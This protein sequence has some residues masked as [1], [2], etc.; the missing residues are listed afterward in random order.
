MLQFKF[1]LVN[2][3][4]IKI[5]FKKRTAAVKIWTEMNLYVVY[6]N[7]TTYC[8][9]RDAD[10]VNRNTTREMDKTYLIRTKPSFSIQ[11]LKT[12]AAHWKIFKKPAR[13][14]V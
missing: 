4:E 5:D 14:I 3:Q 9:D 1:W 6:T 7:Y 13:N 10:W 12:S 2:F 11:F 8:S